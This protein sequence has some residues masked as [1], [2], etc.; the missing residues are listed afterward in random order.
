MDL[1]TA[2]GP[3]HFSGRVTE[4]ELLA[5]RQRFWFGWTKFATFVAAG[6]VVLLIFMTIFLV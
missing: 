5:D 3:T 6:I 2:E 4:D 1:Q